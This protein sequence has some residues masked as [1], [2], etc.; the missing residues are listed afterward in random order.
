[1]VRTGSS[2]L[3]LLVAVA[4]PAAAQERDARV[5]D[6][7]RIGF[8]VGGEGTYVTSEF[9]GG[10]TK[11]FDGGFGGPL[12]PVTFAPLGGFATSLGDFLTATEEQSG[13]GETDPATLTAGDLGVEVGWNARVFPIELGLG[14][15]PRIELR[16]GIPVYRAERYTRRFDVGGGNVGL[17]PDITG[18]G[19][20]MATISPDY[21]AVGGSSVLPVAGTPLALEL[22]HR[23]QALAGSE[24]VL[25][26]SP[27][28]G[29]ELSGAFNVARFPGIITPWRPGDL[30]IGA[31][32]AVLQSFDGLHPVAGSGT[33]YR[34]SA[35]GALRLPTGER[36]EEDVLL[37]RGPDVG[38]QAVVTGVAA[39][40]FAGDRF[41]VSAGGSIARFSA[42][43]VLVAVVPPNGP[44]S[45]DVEVEVA[46]RERARELDLWATPR[47][48]LTRE[49]SVGASLRSERWGEDRQTTGGQATTTPSRARQSLGFSLRYS[50]LARIEEGAAIPAL[51]VAIGY[52]GAFSGGDGLPV[53]RHAFVQVSYLP[54]LWGRR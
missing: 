18:N 52:L 19:A 12:T 31:R 22:Q 28:N 41:W 11:P 50:T 46:R 3:A 4:I 32:I 48:R 17:N 44:L 39:D 51:D 10:G 25:P 40:L 35:S 49:I 33:Q 30:E 6:P 38:F 37:Y 5:L 29:G 14:I 15:L 36:S 43:D 1:M 16:V 42:S 13:G 53:T 9:T 21:A 2:I 24:L 45:G 20:L 54:R 47:L 27:L 8:R 26:E 7:G 23:V 34:L